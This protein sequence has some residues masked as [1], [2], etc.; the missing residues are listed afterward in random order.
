M[1]KTISIMACSPFALL[2]CFSTSVK[3]MWLPWRGLSKTNNSDKRS[4]LKYSATA[5]VLAVS[6]STAI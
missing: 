5:K 1:E 6:I 4:I 3:R 2:P